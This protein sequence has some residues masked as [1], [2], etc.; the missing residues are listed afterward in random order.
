MRCGYSHACAYPV[1]M[2][3]SNLSQMA[4]ISAEKTQTCNNIYQTARKVLRK[5]NLRS[6]LHSSRYISGLREI[7]DAMPTQDLHWKAGYRAYILFNLL[8][9]YLELIG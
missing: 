4:Q 5:S 7:S 2:R 9:S 1:D 6:L 8:H 3:F